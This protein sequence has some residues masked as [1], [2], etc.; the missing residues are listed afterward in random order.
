MNDVNVERNF[1]ENKFEYLLY[2]DDEKLASLKGIVQNDYIWWLWQYESFSIKSEDNVNELQEIFYN[3]CLKNN[4]KILLELNERTENGKWFMDTSDFIESHINYVF[5]HNLEE[6]ANPELIFK[7]LPLKNISLS[8]YQEMY[9]ESSKGDPQ[10]DLTNINPKEFYEKDKIELGELWDE[11]LMFIVLYGDEKLGILN[12]RTMEDKEN[13]SK[14]GA[15]NYLGLLPSQRR[16]GYG[17]IL[18]LMGLKKLKSLGCGS[19]YGGTDSFNK[20]MLKIF[21][22]NNCK[23]AEEQYCYKIKEIN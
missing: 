7:L 12:L 11:E 16:K 5:E 10:I 18:H 8:E 23:R 13:R 21:E 15:I 14:E 4:T 3:D 20:G 17:K 19:Y 2:K 9:Y 6:I 1:F 22:S